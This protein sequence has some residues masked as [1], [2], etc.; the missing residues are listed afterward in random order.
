VGEICL[1]VTAQR[2][3]AR[4]SGDL[5]KRG[6]NAVDAAVAVGK[7]WPLRSTTSIEHGMANSAAWASPAPTMV[8]ASARVS[9]FASFDMDLSG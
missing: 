2:P 4:D 7:R 6:R 3:T 5:P 8:F 9:I 1:V